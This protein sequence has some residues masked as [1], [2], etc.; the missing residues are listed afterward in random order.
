MLGE[1]LSDP[2][3]VEAG[4]TI[5]GMGSVAYGYSLCQQ[6]KTRTRVYRAVPG[7]GWQVTW[8]HLSGAEPG[9]L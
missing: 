3:H 8:L 7:S 4:G 9:R 1:T 5:K 6:N 2:H